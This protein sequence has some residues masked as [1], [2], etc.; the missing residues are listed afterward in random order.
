MCE[1]PL[2]ESELRAERGGGG[3]PRR[4]PP[5]SRLCLPAAA[6]PATPRP[7]TRSPSLASAAPRE[8]GGERWR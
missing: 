2:T 3:C 5:H 1:R 4:S 8:E 6:A 7:V